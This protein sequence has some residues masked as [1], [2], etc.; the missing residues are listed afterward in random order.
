MKYKQALIDGKAAELEKTYEK[1]CND[2]MIATTA[3]MSKLKDIIYQ[4]GFEL[5]LEKAHVPINHKLNKIKVTC[6]SSVF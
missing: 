5:G 6:P 2:S 1:G 3:E 4:P